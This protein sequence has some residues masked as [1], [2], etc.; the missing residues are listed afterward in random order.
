MDID[1]DKPPLRVII[2]NVGV[3]IVA[4]SDTTSTVLS[5]AMYY[6]LRYPAYLQRLR[7][8]LDTTF[9]PVE[10]AT[11]QLDKLAN[12]EMLNAVL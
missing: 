5:G 1:D 3:A 2:A 9:P 6:L 10:H 8:E 7:Q 11:I 4:G 12:L